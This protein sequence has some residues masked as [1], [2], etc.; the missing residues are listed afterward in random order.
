MLPDIK[1]SL[2]ILFLIWCGAAYALM[3]GP[4]MLAYPAMWAGVALLFLVASKAAGP[5]ASGDAS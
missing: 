3:G 1:I 4:V 2:P 5:A